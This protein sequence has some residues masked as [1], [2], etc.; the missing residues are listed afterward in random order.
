M[1]S[2]EFVTR[3]TEFTQEI[4]DVIRPELFPL[5]DQLAAIDPHDLVAPETWFPTES[6]A[7]GFVW[8]M[9]QKLAEK[10]RLS[11]LKNLG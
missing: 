9:F 10:D 2:I 3:F 11:G 7:R 6:A 5:V 4:R 8:S 1:Q